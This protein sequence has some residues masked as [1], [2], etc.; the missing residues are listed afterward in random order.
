[1]I[2]NVATVRIF[3]LAA[4]NRSLNSYYWHTQMIDEDGFAAADS[5]GKGSWCLDAK[6][7]VAVHLACT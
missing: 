6:S 2:R 3:S 7:L 5:L 4:T 1:M